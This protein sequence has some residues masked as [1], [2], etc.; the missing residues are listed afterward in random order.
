MP[1]EQPGKDLRTI[2]ESVAVCDTDRTGDFVGI[3]PVPL[4]EADG[5]ETGGINLHKV[6]QTMRRIDVSD[7]GEYRKL[8]KAKHKV[9]L[10]TVWLSLKT[11][12][13]FSGK[14]HEYYIQSTNSVTQLHRT[15]CLL[16]NFSDTVPE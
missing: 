15:V 11:R 1:D 9:R 4:E 6:E 12:S 7:K 13:F 10:V 3:M 8:I 5:M 14:S 16:H 2:R